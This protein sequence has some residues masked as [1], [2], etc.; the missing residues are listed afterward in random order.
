MTTN[1]CEIA[2]LVPMARLLRELGFEANERTQRC[3]CMLHGGSNRTAFSWTE[4]GLW[5]C[6]SCG[7]GGNSISLV[8]AA[9]RCS[10]REAVGFL[11]VLAGVEYRPGT[12]S[13]E[14]IEVQKRLRERETAEADALLAYEFAAWRWAQDA[15]LQLEAIRRNAGRRL[16]DIHRGEP[17]RWCGESEFAWLALAEVYRQIPRAVAAYSAISFAPAQNRFAFAIN[18]QAHKQLT[19]EALERGWVADEKGYRFEFTL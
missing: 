8:R 14:V 6:H 1:A 12:L 16:D 18:A 17:E 9:R 3:A 11:A 19:D 2:S 15:V 13:R 10:F 5:K 4:A 7:A